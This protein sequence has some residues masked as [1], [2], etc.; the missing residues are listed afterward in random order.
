[1]VVINS[2]QTALGKPIDEQKE[3]EY[4]QTESPSN[5]PTAPRSKSKQLKSPILDKLIIPV[6]QQKEEEN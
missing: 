4:T 3:F 1:M 6:R 5:S 2:T